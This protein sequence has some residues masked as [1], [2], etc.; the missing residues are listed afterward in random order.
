ME[1]A[2]RSLDLISVDDFVRTRVEGQRA[3][4]V[5]GIVY[6]MTGGTDRHNKIAVNA[7]L[8]LGTASRTLGCELFT[9]DMGIQASADTVYYP[10][11][12]AVC[13]SEGDTNLT[14]TKPCLIIEVLSPST[15]SFDEREKRIAYRQILSMRDYLIVHPEDEMVDH[16][17]R[18]DTGT[19][20]W[21]VRNRG[22]VCP[23]TCLGPLAIEDLF[24]GL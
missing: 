7:I 4:L 3:E 15:K 19:W 23:T 5:G 9:S 13:D 2:D 6:L 10:D 21:T 16:H 1:L 14:R 22:D 8:A 24:V 18:E 11:V 17:H 20:S 12:M